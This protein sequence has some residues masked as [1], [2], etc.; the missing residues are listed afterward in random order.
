MS[1]V[2]FSL[3]VDG[4]SDWIALSRRFIEYV[5]NPEPDD[6]ITGL[7]KIFKHTLL[8]AES[9]FHT[10][11]RNSKFC[12]TYVDNNLHVTNWKRKLGCKCQYKHVVDWCGCSPND[13][14]PEDW[15][16]IQNTLT[17]QLY[18]ARKFEPIINQAVILQLELWLFNLEQPSKRVANL[19]GYWQSQYH[20]QDLGVL[21]NDGLQTL[22]SYVKRNL[23]SLWV[24]KF[25]SSCD[26][27]LSELIQVHTFHYNDTYMFSLFNYKLGK[28]SLE[29][30]V[31]AKNFVRL[32]KKSPIM[33]RL[34]ML[35]VTSDYDQKEQISRNFLRVLSPHSEPALVYHFQPR[36]GSLTYNFTSLWISPAGQLHDVVEFSVDDNSLIGHVKPTLR[37]PILPGMLFLSRHIL[38]KKYCMSTDILDFASSQNIPESTAQLSKEHG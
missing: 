30:S 26:L 38:S 27:E 6:L 25:N 13:F 37:Q 7:L 20:Y 24:S 1:T 5:A 32:T 3:Q 15:S 33:E 14:R 2:L 36:Y 34:D 11:L 23:S 4:G 21:P 16:R 28:V 12:D 18:F 29:V 22:S 10:A 8:P 31:E 9:F 19:R 35:M 17:R